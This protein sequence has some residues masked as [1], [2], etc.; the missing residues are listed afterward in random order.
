MVLEVWSQLS[1]VLMPYLGLRAPQ[2]LRVGREEPLLGGVGWVAGWR[3]GRPGA[4]MWVLA[5]APVLTAGQGL[6]PELMA[7]GPDPGLG[8]G[9]RRGQAEG[10][11]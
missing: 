6:L 9:P 5:A 7:P 4:L 1:E 2:E 10:L 3:S 11:A 8:G